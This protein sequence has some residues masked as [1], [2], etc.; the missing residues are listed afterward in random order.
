MELVVKYLK[1]FTKK[2]QKS[3]VVTVEN[4]KVTSYNK[5]CHEIFSMDMPEH[6]LVGSFPGDA[7]LQHIEERNLGLTTACLKCDDFKLNHYTV[8]QSL[9]EFDINII[10]NNGIESNNTSLFK[11][12]VGKSHAFTSDA[13][14]LAWQGDL[15]QN[16]LSVN[17]PL[18]FV[19]RIKK[20]TNKKTAQ[21]FITNDISYCYNN[22]KCKIGEMVA[23]KFGRATVLSK[24]FDGG[25][26]LNSCL[27]VM[28]KNAD[29]FLL[30]DKKFVEILKNVVKLKHTG[31]MFEVTNGKVLTG[32]FRDDGN[33]NF[34]KRSAMLPINFDGIIKTNVV[35]GRISVNP[36]YLLDALLTLNQETVTL[37]FDEKSRQSSGPMILSGNGNKKILLMPLRYE[38]IIDDIMVTYKK[39]IA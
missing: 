1:T 33:R 13:H 30:L 31:L 14:R 28:P 12:A 9:F 26:T 19:T 16:E 5:D 24:P 17:V 11:V 2:Q 20:F 35:N 23:Y 29:S 37:R 27:Q 36:K 15:I 6:E 18:D 22:S 25:L 7:F 10:S 34:L 8:N 38:E 3:L 39:T 4:N 21:L 32:S